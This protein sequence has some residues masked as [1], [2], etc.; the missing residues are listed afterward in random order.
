MSTIYFNIKRESWFKID[1]TKINR[2]FES[3]YEIDEYNV[4][5]YGSNDKYFTTDSKFIRK[6]KLSKL[7][8]SN[9]HDEV[10]DI[11]FDKNVITFLEKKPESRW[12]GRTGASGTVG[13]SG[14]SGTSGIYGTQGMCGT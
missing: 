7:E 9:T 5:G 11:L 2:V 14:T 12:F 1:W 4:D 8:N 6:L 10:I 13:V 3:Y